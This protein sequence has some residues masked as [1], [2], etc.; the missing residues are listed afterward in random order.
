MN[1][2][3]GTSKYFAF[4]LVFLSIHYTIFHVWAWMDQRD[5]SLGY[6][7]PTVGVELGHF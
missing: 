4:P 5:N 6:I 3:I 2:P 7:L 1:E